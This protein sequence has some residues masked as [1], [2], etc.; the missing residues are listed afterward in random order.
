MSLLAYE[1]EYQQVLCELGE[2]RAEDAH[3][4]GLRFSDDARSRHKHFMQHWVIIYVRHLRLARRLSVLMDGELQPQRLGDLRTMLNSC[5]GRMLEAKEAV[6]LNCGDY[7]ALDDLLLD[8][9]V[10]PEEAV[11]PIPS[12]ILEDRADELTERRNYVASLQAHYADTE[13][14]APVSLAMRQPTVRADPTKA[15]PPIAT[16]AASTAPAAPVPLPGTEA[17]EAERTLPFEEAIR[18]LQSCERGRQ[19][20]QRVTFQLLMHR[21]QQYSL[22][23]SKEFSLVTG[24]DKAAGIVQTIVLGYLERKR[25]AQRYVA[26][27]E[28]LG[29]APHASTFN[30]GERLAAELRAEDRK[31]RQRM[32]VAELRQKTVE[33]ESSI[34][35]K[36]GPKTLE[37]MLDEVLM[38]M[39]Y[40]RMESK[41]GPTTIME[42]PSAAEGGSLK[43]LGRTSTGAAPATIKPQRRSTS[44]KSAAGDDGAAGP[45]GAATTSGGGRGGSARRKSAR[46]GKEDES[47]APALP[48]SAFWGPL[49]E[50]QARYQD[51][52]KRK[53]EQSY[54]AGGDLD[55]R[56]DEQELRAELLKG[57][58]GIMSELRATVDQLIMAEVTNL[59]A[60]LQAE[61][62][63]KKKKKGGR[64]AKREPKVKK[65]KLKDPTK[66]VDLDTSLNTAV[67]E[68]KLQLPP[69]GVRLCNFVGEDG[70]AAGPVDKA[71]RA[72]A[73]DEEIR[74][75][76][77]KIL[78]SWND[79]VGAA[80][81]MSQADFEKLFEAYGKQSSW[82]KEPSAADI[83][84]AVAEYCVL[85]LGSQV[86]HD[87]APNIKGLLLYGL[88]GTGKTMLAHAL[89]NESG[90]N[91][92]NL[93]PANFPTTK[94]IPK[95][96][97]L[98]FYVARMKSPSVIYIDD[99]EKIF[100]GKKIKGLPGPPP[101]PGQKGKRGTKGKKKDPLLARGKKLKKELLK[102]MGSIMPHERVMLVACSTEPWTIDPKAVATQFQRAVYCPAPD[103][104][105]RLSLLRNFVRRVLASDEEE[106]ADPAAAAAAV[107]ATALSTATTV[108]VPGDMAVDG[109]G[110]LAMLTDGFTAGH[111][112]FLV[113]RSLPAGKVVR[114]QQY[115]PLTARDFLHVLAAMKAPGPWEG[116]LIGYFQAQLPVQMR[117]ANPVEDFKES[118]EELKKRKS[119]AGPKKPKARSASTATAA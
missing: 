13:P 27:K 116:Q 12:Y 31:A 71:L 64:K 37:V 99:I 34:K 92:F 90:A 18:L 35:A 104:A 52:W 9:K 3:I 40:A 62:D 109:Y 19:A 16:A 6:V 66:G 32:N 43:L 46:G 65:P 44:I 100:P 25:A 14:D 74:K 23:H 75:K 115:E 105:S 21:Q 76:W 84:R 36:E 55:Q 26:E 113:E 88:R 53:F 29:L 22:A 24:K 68:N 98:V 7:L 51:V 57:P 82:L 119:T 69:Q 8:F 118:E 114:A 30:E 72:Q 101:V 4:T 47:L 80:M 59:K 95:L 39:A 10:A 54:M 112:K 85:P 48:L 1:Q 83:R 63:A 87:L 111:L 97:Q 78:R 106:G 28:F 79:N 33:L 117:R 17:V 38:R 86:I 20:R 5:I 58:R 96:V 42:L 61:V 11:V 77:L 49:Q 93:S 102:C 73:P 108:V 45:D 15:L 81:G 56:A 67:F 103:Y 60:R 2:L 89:C 107:A 110:Q 50:G 94:G 91:F 41:D 70:I